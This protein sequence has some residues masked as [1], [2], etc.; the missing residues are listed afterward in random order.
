MPMK[1]RPDKG[2]V[3]SIKYCSTSGENGAPAGRLEYVEY[4]IVGEGET[5]HK[6]PIKKYV[7]NGF[8]AVWDIPNARI[9]WYRIR[10]KENRPE[11]SPPVEALKETD[12]CGD[13]G[14]RAPEKGYQDGFRVHMLMVKESGDKAVFAFIT[15]AA[16]VYDAF[17]QYYN[18]SYEMEENDNPGKLPTII[19]PITVPFVTTKATFRA[20]VFEGGPW[21]DRPEEL[22]DEPMGVPG[23]DYDPPSGNSGN[24][25]KPA[26]WEDED[27][28]SI[29]F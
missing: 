20:P 13:I 7:G 1:A 4:V 26:K 11:G 14:I 12:V 18:D 6:D 28:D 27:P 21:V 2:F 3:R 19:M 9:G 29:P 23:G 5:Q 22:P 16:N 10:S 24:S 17:R 15:T 8:K 25:G